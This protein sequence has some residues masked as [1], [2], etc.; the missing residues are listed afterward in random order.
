[1]R[2][3][4]AELGRSGKSVAALDGALR[5]LP[6]SGAVLEPEFERGPTILGTPF[7][8][9]PKAEAAI[10]PHLHERYD[11]VLL[12]CGALETSVDLLRLAPATDGVVLVV[13]AGR[14]RKEQLDRA[15][16]VIREAQ[17]KLIGF[18]L[19]KRQ[20]PIPAWLYSHL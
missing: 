1:M 4:A 10:I 15:M 11:C 6:T 8:V 17:G 2:G 16:H 20:Y 18:V 19:N 13:E 12:D 3:L 7:A 14:T 5:S 9:E